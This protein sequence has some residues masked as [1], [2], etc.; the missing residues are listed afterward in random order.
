MYSNTKKI[1]VLF[2]CK[3]NICRS[4]LA[5]GIFV[6]ILKKNN[7]SDK[8]VI[9]SAGTCDYHVGNLP[10]DRAI[11]IAL[12]HGITLN[13]S[14]RLFTPEDLKIFD[15]VLVMDHLN[16][17]S[18]TELVKDENIHDKVFL[19][20]SFDSDSAD[21]QNIPDPY[22]GSESDFDEVFDIITKSES[23]FLDYLHTIEKI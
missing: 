18:V 12:D 14:A 17:E 20:R 6:S 9:D 22:Y 19:L 11:K 21:F 10:D 23:G 2:V 8:F 15:Y 16:Y 7:L 1:K 3:G 4:P 5:E 13:S